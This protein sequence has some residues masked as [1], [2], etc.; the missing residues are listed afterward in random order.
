MLD[1]DSEYAAPGAFVC[2]ALSDYFLVPYP[3]S[4]GGWQINNPFFWRE[5]DIAVG[6]TPA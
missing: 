4:G 3:P 1:V 5:L 2:F 6:A